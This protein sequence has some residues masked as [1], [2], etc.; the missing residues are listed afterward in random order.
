MRYGLGFILTVNASN[1][2]QGFRR[3]GQE[4]SRFEGR[5]SRSFR[6]LEHRQNR[7]AKATTGFVAALS[8]VYIGVAAFGAL[9][10]EAIK[11]D[12]EIRALA[13]VTK[14]TASQMA[15]LVKEVYNV[16]RGFKEFT[17]TEVAKATRQLAQAGYSM[18]EGDKGLTVLRSSLDAVIASLGS[19]NADSAIQLGITLDKSF[20]RGD[21]GITNLFDTVGEA[22][23]MFPMQM[24]QVRTALGYSTAAAQMYNQSLEST[25]LALGTLIPILGTASKAGV[26]QRNALAGLSKPATTRFLTEQGIKVRDAAGQFRDAME[27]MI[28]IDDALEKSR[29]KDRSE[30]TGKTEMLLHRM[31]G[32]RGKAMFT[33]I[34]RLPQTVSDMPGMKGVIRP[35][36]SSARDAYHAMQMRLKGGSPGALQRLAAQ[37]GESSVIIDKK[38]KAAF[39]NL[40]ESIGTELLP[41]LDNV[42]ESLTALF[43]SMREGS[44][45]FSMLLTPMKHLG[46]ALTVITPLLG[47]AAAMF[48]ARMAGGMIGGA[49]MGGRGAMYGPMTSIGSLPSSVMNRAG[50]GLGYRAAAFLGM[51]AHQGTVSHDGARYQQASRT[52]TGRFAFGNPAQAGM[53]RVGG[54]VMA[55]ASQIVSA[56]M[57]FQ[58]VSVGVSAA[59]KSTLDKMYKGDMERIELEKQQRLQ[60]QKLPEKSIEFIMR[61]LGVGA[62]LDDKAITE[63]VQ[64]GVIT[65]Y[66]EWKKAM[67]TGETKGKPVEAFNAMVDKFTRARLQTIAA[68]EDRKK[69]SKEMEDVKGSYRREFLRARPSDATLKKYQKSYTDTVLDPIRDAVLPPSISSYRRGMKGLGIPTQRGLYDRQ[70]SSATTGGAQSEALGTL[71]HDAQAFITAVIKR[72]TIIQMRAAG[73]SWAEINKKTGGYKSRDVTP[74]GFG[75]YGRSMADYFAVNKWFEKIGPDEGKA[76]RDKLLGDQT[77]EAP[78]RLLQRLDIEGD[79]PDDIGDELSHAKRILAV[80]K[81]YRMTPTKRL[82]TPLGADRDYQK[83]RDAGGAALLHYIKNNT[84]RVHLTNAKE[85]PN[86]GDD[87]NE[88]TN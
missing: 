37:M 39:A 59:I 81:E 48:A 67:G 43:D 7:M 54:M 35:G 13:A 29:R 36:I 63:M 14:T 65:A 51:G 84:L 53:R 83:A 80:L 73:K 3:A 6:R 46:N 20:G 41:I 49:M 5:A 12:F 60:Q 47:V 27:I 50:G 40:T 85:I 58:A 87:P 88:E 15:H 64:S 25:I 32:I 17:V 56:I 33:A 77:V 19:L 61:R 57:I 10:K 11:L 31:F 78:H 42:K 24:D 44:S 26:A 22:I 62:P 16:G 66:V 72:A 70:Y 28:D 34:Q 9:T 74:E 79:D 76:F 45:I 86:P 82:F 30:R 38:F 8:G 21:R 1:F 2:R 4:V 68:P 52:P 71:P 55:G 18:A 75:E 69:F 23:N